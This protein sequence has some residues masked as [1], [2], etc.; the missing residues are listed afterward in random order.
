MFS[1]QILNTGVG[2]VV[3]ATGRYLPFFQEARSLNTTNVCLGLFLTKM[4][5]G[6]YRATKNS[7]GSIRFLD[8]SKLC[9]V[10]SDLKSEEEK[11]RKKINTEKE[12]VGKA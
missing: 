5:I 1:V 9:Q 6:S 2:K 12:W 11:K 7:K 4:M 8:R 3:G 10:P